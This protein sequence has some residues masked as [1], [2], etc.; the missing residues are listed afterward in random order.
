[1]DAYSG[2]GIFNISYC[3]GLMVS[4]FQSINGENGEIVVTSVERKRCK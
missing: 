3:N 4:T 1:M 2:Y